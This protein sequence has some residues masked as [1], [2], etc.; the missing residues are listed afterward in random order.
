MGKSSSKKAKS[1]AD[2]ITAI[3]QTIISVSFNVLIV[4]VLVML[5]L[6]NVPKAF[7]FGKAIFLDEAVSDETHAKSIVVTIPNGADAKKI[8]QLVAKADLV[9]DKNVFWIKLLLSD[10]KDHIKAGTYTLSTGDKPSQ[11][12]EKLAKPDTVPNEENKDG[13]T[14]APTEEQRP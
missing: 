11:I 12:I 7:H 13:E 8:A 6:N 14:Q 3:V 9:D 2:G 5:V 10:E 4:A 1:T